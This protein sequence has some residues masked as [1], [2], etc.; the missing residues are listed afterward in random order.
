MA[1]KTEAPFLST[2]TH[3]A[4]APVFEPFSWLP[5]G[6]GTHEARLLEMAK[7]VAAG[8]ALALQL[9]ERSEIE[10]DNGLDAP[11]LSRT[12]CGVLQ[13]L[14][15]SSCHLLRDALDDTFDCLNDAAAKGGV[16]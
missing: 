14:S 16:R 11:L 12:D 7:D 9:V 4:L 5:K 3:A 13:R 8:V 6:T 2:G 1:K 15:I 10:I